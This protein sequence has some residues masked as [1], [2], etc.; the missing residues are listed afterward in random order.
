[1][2]LNHQDVAES[3]KRNERRLK[4]LRRS[5]AKVEGE[6]TSLEAKMME[7]SLSGQSSLTEDDEEL[8]RYERLLKMKWILDLGEALQD[9]ALMQG[10]R[11]FKIISKCSF[12][13]LIEDLENKRLTFC[14]SM[15]S[16]T[17]LLR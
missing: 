7:M 2:N 15:G 1:M 12:Q 10:I 5:I 4:A 13:T 9:P 8:G 14:I 3:M 17:L 11:C 16:W 6:K